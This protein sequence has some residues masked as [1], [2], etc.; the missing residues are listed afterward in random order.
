MAASQLSFEPI[1]RTEPL[2][3]F[4]ATVR[5][6]SAMTTGEL[7]CPRRSGDLL[8]VLF[9]IWSLFM[10]FSIAGIIHRLSAPRHEI[11][12]SWRLWRRLCRDLRLRGRNCSRESGAFL[13]GQIE[14]GRRRILDYV[15]YDDLD[16]HS[17]D[18][19]IVRFDGRYFSELW[20]YCRS[21]N[22]KVVADVHVHPGSPSQSDSDKANPMISLRGHVAFILP[23]FASSPWS[24]HTL[25]IYR[26]EGAKRWTAISGAFRNV[27]FHIGI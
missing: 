20:A 2:S 24:R 10:N 19:G 15:L 25:G 13:L 5:A 18:T 9:N 23:N 1:G 7:K 11:S 4:R 8:M 17:L 12:C 22:M 16:P 21:R 3:I 26:Y 6:S 27:F 14:Q